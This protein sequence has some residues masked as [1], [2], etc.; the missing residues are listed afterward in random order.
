[1]GSDLLRRALPALFLSLAALTATDAV[2]AQRAVSPA[3]TLD[4]APLLKPGDLLRV[5]IYREP[6]LSGEYQVSERGTIVLPRLGEI[7]LASW[8]IDSIRP[9]LTRA[10]AEYLRDPTIEVTPLRRI[11]VTGAV[12]RPNLYPVDPTMTVLDALALAGGAAPDGVRDRVEL[13]RGTER[14]EARLDQSSSIADLK[15]RSGDQLYVP[16]RSWL[17]RNTWL[18]S[19]LIGATVTFTT[20]MLTR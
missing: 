8:P 6:D 17:S 2:S 7:E 14:L 13:R 10:F 15:L 12:L 1:M 9:R 5:R 18:V 16:Q 20:I 11:A 3:L 4:A 19:T